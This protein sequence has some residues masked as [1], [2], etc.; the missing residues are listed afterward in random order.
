[1]LF[2]ER[3]DITIGSIYYQSDDEIALHKAIK[4]VD[5]GS[6]SIVDFLIQNSSPSLNKQ[7]KTNGNTALHLCSEYNRTE[8][9]KL[10]L[11]TRAKLDISQ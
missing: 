11:R 9:M 7:T 5:R 2:M 8:C 4:Q 10:L 3:S 6:L 1:M